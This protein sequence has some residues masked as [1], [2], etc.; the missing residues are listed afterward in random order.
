MRFLTFIE[1]L[2]PDYKKIEKIWTILVPD[3]VLI[4][5]SKKSHCNENDSLTI[6]MLC[7]KMDPSYIFR[8]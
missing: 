3:A 5:E 6:N 4:Y 7:C 1:R 2:R 8:F